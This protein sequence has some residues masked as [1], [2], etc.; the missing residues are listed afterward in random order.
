MALRSRVA[1]CCG[2]LGAK[3]VLQLPNTDL[4]SPAQ[5]LLLT[6]WMGSCSQVLPM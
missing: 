3:A 6:V 4:S 2:E 1:H 5:H